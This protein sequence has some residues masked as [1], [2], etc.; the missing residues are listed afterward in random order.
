MRVVVNYKKIDQ[1]NITF[2]GENMKTKDMILISMFAALTAIGAYISI[3]TQPVP[4]TFQVLF[5][6]YSGVLLGSKKGALSQIVYVLLGLVGLPIFAGGKGGISVI[7]SPTFGFL[8]G[9]IVCSY[10]VGLI[11]EKFE[12][13]N[14]FKLSFAT[15]SGIIIVYLVGMPYFYF[16]FNNVLN[17]PTTLADS[18]KLAVYPFLAQDLVKCILVAATSLKVIPILK[19][20]GYLTSSKK[21]DILIKNS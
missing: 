5:C 15:V 10:V 4:F 7:G 19:K 3:P 13:V 8:L 18:M 6:M 1:L 20:S 12:T 14:I 11:I 2:R 17:T 9:F 21:E 16:I